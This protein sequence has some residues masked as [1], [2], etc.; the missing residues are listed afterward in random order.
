MD[1]ISVPVDTAKIGRWQRELTP[2]QIAEF[3]KGA[4]DALAELGYSS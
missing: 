1:R 2:E 4:G 3:E